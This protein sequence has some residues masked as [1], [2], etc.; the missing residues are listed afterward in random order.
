MTYTKIFV[1]FAV[2]AVCGGVGTYFGM[3]KY[4]E[5]KADEEIAEMKEF[6]RDR[7]RKHNEEIAEWKQGADG[8]CEV[9]D[10]L[11]EEV[12]SLK[13]IIK[14]NGY[15][16]DKP[17]VQQ[18]EEELAEREAP[19]EESGEEKPREG[20]RMIAPQVVTLEEFE[21]GS[22]AYDHT[23]LTYYMEDEV[24]LYDADYEKVYDIRRLIGQAGIDELNKCVSKHGGVFYIRN[25]SFGQMYEVEVVDGSSGDAENYESGF[26][27]E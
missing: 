16:D 7:E 22:P 8:D 27:N 19:I 26:V 15:S 6:M 21:D 24:M 9:I 20:R 5:V 10:S 4:F 25:Q 11:T 2:G 14:D 13:K 17:V 18:Q 1:S 23:C 12:N 3:K